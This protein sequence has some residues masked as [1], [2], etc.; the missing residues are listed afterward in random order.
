MENASEQVEMAEGELPLSQTLL[1]WLATMV[2][3]R[4]QRLQ[5]GLV[6]PPCLPCIK[7]VVDFSCNAHLQQEEGLVKLLDNVLEAKGTFTWL[8]HSNTENLKALPFT[9]RRPYTTC[10]NNVRHA[11]SFSKAVVETSAEILSSD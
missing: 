1:I 9:S 5:T 11:F 3:I 10:T 4:I 7:E 2:F 8:L 6:L